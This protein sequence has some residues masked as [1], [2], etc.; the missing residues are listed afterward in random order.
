[1]FLVRVLP[2]PFA[3]KPLLKVG[4]ILASDQT[5]SEKKLPFAMSMVLGRQLHA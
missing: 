2:S 5:Q 3:G 4:K 1:M